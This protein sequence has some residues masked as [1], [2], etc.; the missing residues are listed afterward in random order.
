MPKLKTLPK[1]EL[2]V[3]KV[4]WKQGK[5]TVNEVR[6]ALAKKQSYAYTT[7]ATTLTNLEKK[8]FLAHDVDGRT[9]VYYALVKEEEISKGAVKDLLDHLFDG[10][11]ERLVTALLQ[12][13]A[14]SDKEL[15]RLQKRIAEYRKEEGET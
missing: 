11:A 9:Y 4:I 14:I 12:T 15:K 2:Q 8:G 6:D 10:S 3:I 7:I 13:Q 5:A 1:L